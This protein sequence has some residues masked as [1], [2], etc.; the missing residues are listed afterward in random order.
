M[1]KMKSIALLCI[2]IIGVA[3]IIGYWNSQRMS[4]FVPDS[5]VLLDFQ[6]E[7]DNGDYQV[8]YKIKHDVDSASHVDAV[9]ILLEYETEYAKKIG[10]IEC[11]YQYTRSDDLWELKDYR[12][13]EWETEL[14][15]FFTDVAPHM[16]SDG[17]TTY[18]LHIEDIDTESMTITVIYSIKY[19]DEPY[20]QYEPV[21]F[22][23]NYVSDPGY[24]YF[25]IDLPVKDWSGDPIT[26]TFTLGAHG[27]NFWCV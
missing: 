20:P 16:G 25:K 22:N 11:W 6:S 12:N 3:C 27:I 21:T 19:E 18:V 9:T 24:Y 13:C 23:L 14:K 1:R 26:A 17:D 15:S 2:I 4:E 8:D 7:I 10:K 5:V